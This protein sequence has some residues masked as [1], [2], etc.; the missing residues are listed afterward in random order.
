MGA[1]E[2]VGALI[3]SLRAA[4]ALEVRASSPERLEAVVQR[5]DLEACCRLLAQALGEPAKPF[6]AT[7]TFDSR[8]AYAVKSLGGIRQEQCLYL[9]PEGERY[10]LYAALWPWES[11]PD[12]VTLHVGIYDRTT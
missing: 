3:T 5:K 8:T 9:K 10:V 11:N 6:G 1:T 7:A 4:A 12:R 2:A